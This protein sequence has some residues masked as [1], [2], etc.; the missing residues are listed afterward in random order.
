M[1]LYHFTAH[2]CL[3]DIM[4]EG[5]S[6]GEVPLSDHQTL[7]AVNLTT[8][9]EPW[10]HGLDDGGNVITEAEIES[11][12]QVS[13][14]RIPTGTIIANKRAVRIAVKIPSS[15]RALKQWLP[16]ARK[17]I[18]PT[19]LKRLHAAAGRDPK[20]KTWWLYW[21]TIPPSA[22]VAVDVLEPDSEEA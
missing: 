21:G 6:R 14:Q 11:W 9:R 12:Y 15:D 18:D 3:E 7:Q 16:W 22:F 5:L 1:I 10:G 19:Y 13:G 4:R 2:I 17:N 20:F 8:S